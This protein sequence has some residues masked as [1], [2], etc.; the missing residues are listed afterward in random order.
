MNKMVRIVIL[1]LFLVFSKTPLFAQ[2]A[3]VNDKDGYVNVRSS[4][5]IEPNNI[6]DTLHNGSIVWV[7]DIDDIENNNWKDIQFRNSNGGYVYANRIKYVSDYQQIASVFEDENKIIFKDNTISVEIK[8][9][10]FDKS[11]HIITYEKEGSSSW[12]SK[13]DGKD[14][15]GTDGDLPRYEYEYINITIN[16][17]KFF[18]PKEAINN[19]FEPDSHWVKV[20]YDKANDILYIQSMNSDGAGGYVVAWK[21]EKGIYKEQAVY[22]GI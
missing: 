22:P 15:W 20:N 4:P 10:E 18:L 6:I 8:I 21:I 2:F 11:K 12:I 13:I 17:S 7:L 9:R 1:I 14:F 16:N 19:L 3:I 5:K